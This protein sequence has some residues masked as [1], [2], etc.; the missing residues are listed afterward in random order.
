[1]KKAE[2]A[3]RL[4]ELERLSG[5]ASR[6]ARWFAEARDM[7]RSVSAGLRGE[8]PYVL[9][10][11]SVEEYRA[12]ESEMIRRNQPTVSALLQQAQSLPTTTG[13][14]WY[15]P[16]TAR[17]GIIA[18]TFLAKSLEGTAAFEYLHP[19]T[20][21]E[22]VE[23]IDVLLVTSAWRGLN[24]EWHGVS[25]MSPARDLIIQEIIPAAKQRNV[26]VV[27]YSK[28]DPPNYSK[29]IG[30]ARHCDVILTS[31]EEMLPKYQRDAPG[32][33]HF[34]ALPFG[35]SYLHHNP[36]GSR[37]V[38]DR[39]WTFAGSWH[40]EKYAQRRTAAMNI[41]NGLVGAGEQLYIFDRNSELA[42]EK[43]QFPEA[44][45]PNMYHAVDH[46]DLLQMQRLLPVAINL[47]SVQN[48]Q[49]MFANRALELQAMGTLIMSNYNAGLNSQFPHILM[50]DSEVDARD[51]AAS[52]TDN[53]VSRAQLDGVRSAF[54]GN[55][56]FE[57]MVTILEAAGLEDAAEEIVP[58][59]RMIVVA[60]DRECYEQFIAGQT[61]DGRTA[62]IT[63]SQVGDERGGPD[64]DI[65]V[66]LRKTDYPRTYLQDLANGFKFTD[67]DAVEAVASNDVA[68]FE[69][70][71]A[72]STGVD[73]AT[74]VCEGSDVGEAIASATTAVTVG[75]AATMGETRE[76]IATAEPELTVI[77]PVYNNGRHL[78]YKC[79][80]SLRRSSIFSKM[81]VLLVDDGSTDAETLETVRDLESTFANVHSFS[82]ADGGSG[83]ASR[84]RNKGLELADT[85][86]VTYLD[87]DNE[88]VNDGYAVLLDK[89][90]NMGVDFGI[91]NMVKFKG[92]RSVVGNNGVLSP[93]LKEDFNWEVPEGAL[94]SIKFQPMSIQALVAN[95]AW[96]KSIGIQQPVGAV[97]QDSYFFQQMLYYARRVLR[98]GLPIHSYYAEVANSTV[99]TLGP[100]FYEK[101]IPLEKDRSSWLRRVG[102]LGS[103]NE[104]RLEPFVKGWFIKKLERVAP[105]HQPRCR[106]LIHQLAAYYGPHE[107]KDEDLRAWF[108]AVREEV[109]AER[110][111]EV[112]KS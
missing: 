65:V 8:L 9:P 11:D 2:I 16:S 79:M 93:V 24:G 86:Y 98:I 33:R 44:L 28:E 73:R 3:A 99:N 107:W 69:F 97:G 82:F 38:N 89:V 29:F 57:R 53:D 80:A 62:F 87:P 43:Y 77:V 50:P 101:Y 70:V 112:V 66:T 49:T 94:S 27:F 103:Y 31:A 35:V 26:P 55:T 109:G 20:W 52:L 22:Q 7:P 61:Y 1:M 14:R 83:S 19:D 34:S 63:P 40:R 32:A 17:I 95:T 71:E 72:R 48:S 85:E 51:W 84:P 47:N 64:G 39:I 37:R 100:K 36:L 81:K 75:L 59:H 30:I 106:E 15:R 41:F 25:I 104:T 21:H 13:Q 6:L 10:S 68:T 74:W 42:L 45:L 56:A 111:E 90:R 18:D 23:R 110:S 12:R 54:T 76:T 67:A 5:E 58:D 108:A 105:E 102:L 4:K 91:G 88:A 78:R 96:L 60:D 92:T 46:G